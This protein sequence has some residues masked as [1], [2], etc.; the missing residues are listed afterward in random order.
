MNPSRRTFL[1]QLTLIGSAALLAPVL[2]RADSP[3]DWI[4]IGPAA[5][6]KQDTFKR[7]TVP[8]S[9]DVLFITQNKDK[10]YLAL[11][12]KCT[13][14]GCEVN[15]VSGDKDFL[16]PCHHGRF[17]NQGNVLN[18]P[19]QKPLPKWATKVDDKGTL[20]VQ[21]PADNPPS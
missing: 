1:K 11:S 3:S 9:A 16:C 6:Y 8:N 17:D 7:A 20:L 2:A 15:W 18:G 5:D 13:H 10:S 21:R 14:R 19:P 4:A 12:A